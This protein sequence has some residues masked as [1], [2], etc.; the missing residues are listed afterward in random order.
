MGAP[1]L[2]LQLQLRVLRLVLHV[3]GNRM[4]L[5]L[6]LPWGRLQRH[7]A[8]LETGRVA[9]Y[10][11]AGPGRSG[12]AAEHAA[13]QAAAGR[14]SGLRGLHCRRHGQPTGAIILS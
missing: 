1:V 5:L 13:R 4:R 6:Q 2:L 14:T 7:V 3:P 10:T 12:G 11:P 9:G 8:V